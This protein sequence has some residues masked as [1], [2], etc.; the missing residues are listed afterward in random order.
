VQ[1]A[2][3]LRLRLVQLDAHRACVAWLSKRACGR[4]ECV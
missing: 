3:S 1:A 2:S 4:R